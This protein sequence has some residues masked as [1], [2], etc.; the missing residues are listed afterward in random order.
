MYFLLLLQACNKDAL[1][2]VMDPAF[3]PE[4]PTMADYDGGERDVGRLTMGPNVVDFAERDLLVFV[5]DPDSLGGLASRLGAE[6]VYRSVPAD[7]GFDAEAVVVLR[8]PDGLDTGN[9]EADLRS[10]I[11]EGNGGA[12]VSSERGLATLATAAML[13][14]EGRAVSVDFRL[15]PST[16]LD[17]ASTEGSTDFGDE[18]FS[19]PHLSNDSTA[20]YGVTRAWQALELEGRLDTTVRVAVIDHEIVPDRDYGGALLAT[21]DNVEEAARFHGTMVASIV[22]SPADDGLGAAG[23]AAGVADLR[24]FESNSGFLNGHELVFAAN[25]DGARVVNLSWGVAWPEA[26]QWLLY[27]PMNWI[28]AG[29]GSGTLVVAAAG[30]EGMDITAHDGAFG[31]ESTFYYPCEVTGVYCVGGE[32]WDADRRDTNSNYGDTVDLYGPFTVLVSATDGTGGVQMVDGT[33]FASPFVAGA[34]A[35]LLAA[36]PTLSSE[37]LTEVLTRTSHRR[38]GGLRAVDVD[39]AV[40]DVLGNVA[41]WVQIT[42]DDADGRLDECQ[43]VTLFA[44]VDDDVGDDAFTYEWTSDRD[45]VFSHSPSVTTVALTPGTHLISLTVADP[46]GA[47]STAESLLTIEN[48]PPS[49][50]I[51]TPSQS[52][53]VGERLDLYADWVDCDESDRDMT[54]VVWT[55]GATRLGSGSTVDATFSAGSHYVTATVTDASGAVDTDSVTL[56]VSSCDDNPPEVR[57]TTPS[58][59][60]DSS[61]DTN[62]FLYTGYDTTLGLYYVDVSVSATAEDAEDGTLPASSMGWT[63]DRTDLQGSVLPVSGGTVRLYGT[64]WGEQHVVTAAVRDSAG[65]VGQDSRLVY[66]WT[67][68]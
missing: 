44:E 55:D 62:S 43:D 64:C 32:R 67:L 41:P 27:A 48:S 20:D 51:S 4:D 42:H 10:L 3:G 25:R 31:A 11:P 29:S 18:A 59:D 15:V 1:T 46:A 38:T 47:N 57:I 33:S 30:N 17:G 9:V 40:R 19:W 61:S 63:T 58:T 36:E 2:L 60:S 8:L 14:D 66:V 22:A 12:T 68:C 35:L 37:Q 7:L 16:F 23:V 13:A 26:F 65:N 34:A 45:G 21:T 53:C 54:S 28:H 5:D 50:D 56:V 49:I 24:L 52:L 6:E 39:A